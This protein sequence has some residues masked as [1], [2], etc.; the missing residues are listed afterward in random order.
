MNVTDEVNDKEYAL[1]KGEEPLQIGTIQEIANAE[2]VKE[3]TIRFYMTPSYRKRRING[4][5]F[6]EVVCLDE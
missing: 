6:R 3:D 5:N 4:K 2:N 1:Y